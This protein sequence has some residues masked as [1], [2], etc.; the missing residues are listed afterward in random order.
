MTK[1]IKIEGMMCPHCEAHVK[2]A[3][4]ALEGVENVTPSHVEKKATVESLI[5]VHI[6]GKLLY[7]HQSIVLTSQTT[8]MTHMLD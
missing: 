5:K 3:L 4:E 6:S 2:K 8:N 7:E 1:T